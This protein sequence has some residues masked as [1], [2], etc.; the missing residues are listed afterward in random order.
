MVIGRIK[1]ALS[2]GNDEK[3]EVLYHKYS[4]I[5]LENKK[6][7]EQHRK[8][9]V[10]FKLSTHKN[11]ADHLIELYDVVEQT[12]RDSFKITAKDV[13]MQNLMIDI[14]K[15]EKRMKELMSDFSIEEIT[16][17]ERFYDPELHEVASYENANGMQKGLIMKTVKKG[18]K[19]RGSLVKKPKVVVTK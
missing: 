16:P 3:Y 7:K 6:L 15:V 8:D 13:N 5:K 10:N 4:Q 19:F 2:G 18:F 9:L 14:N 12:K 17:K 1:D 11:V